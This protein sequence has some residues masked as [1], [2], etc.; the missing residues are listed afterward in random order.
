ME[1]AI[2]EIMVRGMMAVRDSR[3]FD[4]RRD[5]K[6]GMKLSQRRTKLVTK[7]N[8]RAGFMYVMVQ[9]YHLSVAARRLGISCEN[10]PEVFKQEALKY[11]KMCGDSFLHFYNKKYV[12]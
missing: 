9:S 11:A 7:L 5:V 2:I 12:N 10:D 1:H 6:K 4:E 3:L 8:L